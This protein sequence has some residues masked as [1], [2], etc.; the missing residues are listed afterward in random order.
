VTR[1]RL[2]SSPTGYSKIEERSELES[3]PP[4]PPATLRDEMREL[5]QEVRE[6]RGAVYELKQAAAAAEAAA[7][8]AEARA[9]E[10]KASARHETTKLI[11]GGLVTVAL[12]F[13]GGRAA[14][15]TPEATQT[16]VVRTSFEI[17][18]DG[19]KILE[20]D[21]ARGACITRVVEKH[22]APSR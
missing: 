2:P 15:P 7:A 19:C 3:V 1:Q 12:A 16:R 9:A 21:A 13:A 10:A 6:L 22:A 18:L 14:T 11:V 20:G 8:A 4:A 17:E 5:R